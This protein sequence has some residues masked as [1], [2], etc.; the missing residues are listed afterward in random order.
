[1]TCV[2]LLWLFCFALVSVSVASWAEE[3]NPQNDN[4]CCSS[5]DLSTLVLEVPCFRIGEDTY[6]LSLSYRGGTLFKLEHFSPLSNS[7]CSAECCGNFDF[8]TGLIS[9]PCLLVGESSLWATFNL[10]ADND[11]IFLNLQGYG[12]NSPSVAEIKEI[13]L[14][15]SQDSSSFFSF[16]TDAYADANTFD[17]FAEPWCTV[18][19]RLCGHFISLGSKA[20]E[21]V[22]AADIPASTSFPAEVTCQD[23][24]V[25]DTCIFKNADGSYTAATISSH[26]KPDNCTHRITLLYK[27]L[28]SSTSSCNTT[29]P[30]SQVGKKL[31]EHSVP[32]VNNELWIDDLPLAVGKDSSI[33]YSASGG[34][35]NWESSRI[36]AINKADGSLK[37]KTEPLA[38]WH[39]NSNIVVGDDGTVYVLSYTKLYSINPNTG[40]FNWVWE[41]PEKIGANYTYGEVGGLALASNGDLIFKTNGSGS[42]YRALY[43]VGSNGQTKWHHF[44]GAEVTPITIGYQGVIYDF[45]HESAGIY[46][47]A[48]DPDTGNEKWKIPATPGSGYNNIVVADNG[49]LIWRDN[50]KLVRSS[51][52]DGHLI[53]QTEALSN[54][55]NKVLDTHGYIYLYDQWVGTAVFDS[56]TGS[57]KD[58]RINVASEPAIDGLGRLCGVMASDSHLSVNDSSGSLVWESKIDDFYGKTVAISSDKVIY[59]ANGKKVYALQGDAALASSGWPKFSHDN[60]NT[61]N[62]GKH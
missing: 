52:V 49:D 51:S 24:A 41:V 8:A 6:S 55:F 7:S 47:Y 12:L 35:S 20:L 42:Y 62:A 37:W 5:I 56:Q 23:L 26:T 32:V 45:G 44:I 1:M 59:V 2:V 21:N 14:N 16:V 36:Y 54:H 25:G 40:A 9:L 30:Q 10:V 60:R 29:A 27:D 17:V 53:W 15:T 33:Y 3:T 38:T 50:D 43:S 39:V 46:L 19:P 48:Y 34:Q 13:T 57:K 28:G 18:P 11:G 58:T 61:F 4:T 22:S 31:W